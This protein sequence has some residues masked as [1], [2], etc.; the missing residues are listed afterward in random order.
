MRGLS[1]KAPL[2][3]PPALAPPPMGPFFQARVFV[4]SK[5]PGAHDP[6]D[7]A[8]PP[9]TSPSACWADPRNMRPAIALLEEI[10][11]QIVRCDRFGVH[12]LIDPTTMQAAFGVTL[13]PPAS[14]EGRWQI[15]DA[16][17][18]PMRV[19]RPSDPTQAALIRGIVLAEAST[20]YGDTR[21][22]T[23]Y[24]R[25]FKNDGP[26]QYPYQTLPHQ[27]RRELCA[28]DP[29]PGATRFRKGSGVKIIVCDTGFDGRHPYWKQA[30]LDAAAERT[31]Q[32]VF[33]NKGYLTQRR[34]LTTWLKDTRKYLRESFDAAL[35]A[36]AAFINPAPGA[37]RKQLEQDLRAKLFE[38]VDF[39]RSLSPVPA[40]V[41]LNQDK[42]KNVEQKS[43]QLPSKQFIVELRAACVGFDK[44]AVADIASMSGRLLRENW[45]APH[46]TA[47]VG[48]ILA[49]APEAEITVIQTMRDGLGQPN[50]VFKKYYPNYS[51][52]FSDLIEQLHDVRPQ[53]VCLSIGTNTLFSPKDDIFDRNEVTI[54]DFKQLLDA[55]DE[56]GALFIQATGNLDLLHEPAAPGSAIDYDPAK[57]A[58][59]AEQ[60]VP[61]ANLVTSPSLLS[62]GGAYWTYRHD[63]A[64]PG[65]RREVA[66]SGVAL[67]YRA[68][69]ATT[70]GVIKVPGICGL[71]GPALPDTAKVVAGGAIVAPV[72]Y[73]AKGTD[74][75]F[76]AMPT[77][78]GTSY[79]TPHVC[80][81]AALVLEKYPKTRPVELRNRLTETANP[82]TAYEAGNP[83]KS[84]ARPDDT[85]DVLAPTATDEKPRLVDLARAVEAKWVG[86]GKTVYGTLAPA[87]TRF[88]EAL[89]LAKQKS[90]SKQ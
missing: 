24:E 38:T 86:T 56:V 40:S 2:A 29:G 7:R 3:A 36:Y 63:L 54:A 44:E 78:S 4:A 39:F 9:P 14:G 74:T 45:Y 81:V 12:I 34:E 79:A 28:E 55:S 71:C 26:K 77:I 89:A 72:R 73:S 42:Y 84:F 64:G 16:A 21:T 27:L 23:E 70:G 88:Q 11:C 25:D 5:R 57:R 17:G 33:P 48:Q 10:G 31:A 60:F 18:K 37:D 62:V 58:D 75:P 22:L 69:S 49:I 6:L 51:W 85:D 15:T 50:D 61:I 76:D 47:V 80:G 67:G 1:P 87:A 68:E 65:R 32:R 30:G 35:P 83:A 53:L 13:G 52:N 8:G 66:A 19:L 82:I 46:G 43:P 41:K 20:P 90:G 59:K